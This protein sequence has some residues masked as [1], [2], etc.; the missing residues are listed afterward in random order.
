[1][2]W[3]ENNEGDG[4]EKA[5]K[6]GE[7]LA[8]ISAENLGALSVSAAG[9]GSSRLPVMAQSANINTGKYLSKATMAY[10]I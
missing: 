10:V 6:C 2:K 3:R 1:M 9:L 8:A 4:L 5:A 7:S